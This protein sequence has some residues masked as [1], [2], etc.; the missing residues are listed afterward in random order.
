[1]NGKNSKNIPSVFASLKNKMKPP[2]NHNDNCPKI[3]IN[4]NLYKNEYFE[5]SAIFHSSP[6]ISSTIWFMS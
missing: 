4:I 5:S 6:P 2:K 1:M 3:R